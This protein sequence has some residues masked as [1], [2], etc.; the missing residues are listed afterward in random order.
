MSDVSGLALDPFRRAQPQRICSAREH[1]GTLT[2]HAPPQGVGIVPELRRAAAG[3]GVLLGQVDKVR[4][5]DQTQEAD[6]QGGD[7]LLKANDIMDVNIYGK[8]LR[9]QL[10]TG[11]VQRG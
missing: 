2:H 3:D 10:S 4:G 7:Q 1:T 9:E 6:V 5:E 8:M 11:S